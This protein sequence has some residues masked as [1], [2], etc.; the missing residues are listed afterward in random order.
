MAVVDVAAGDAVAVDVVADVAVDT[1]VVVADVAVDT[2]VV[3]IAVG[4]DVETKTLT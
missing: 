3:E 1:A 2:A 4:S